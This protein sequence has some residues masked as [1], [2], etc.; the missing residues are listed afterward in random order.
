MKEEGIHIPRKS[1]EERKKEIWLA[2]KEVFLE[3]G[4]ERTTMEDII[5]RTSLSKGGMYH[6]YSRTKDILF[7][8]LWSHNET[9]LE[10]NIHQEILE[11]KISFQQ[12]MELM[13]DAI[14][15]KMCRTTPERRLFA[16]F[17]SQMVHDAEIQEVFLK[18]EDYF[19]RGLCHRLGIEGD[20]QQQLQLRSISRMING[21]TLFQNI[22]PY[23]ELLTSHQEEVRQMIRQQLQVFLQQENRA[24]KTA[25]TTTTNPAAAK[26]TAV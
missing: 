11:K 4:Y 12:Q 6:Y 1:S 16:I 23:P 10:I 17:M 26:V 13:L 9:Y 8:I 7:D 5:A 24:I 2:A 22:L 25:S 18:L 20:P 14:V 15:D 21:F 3:K 19:L